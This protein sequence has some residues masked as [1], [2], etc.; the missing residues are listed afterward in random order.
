MVTWV[1]TALLPLCYR[2]VTRVLPDV[3]RM[4][5]RMLPGCSQVLLHR[6]G[7]LFFRL[8]LLICLMKLIL[9]K[10]SLSY[11]R[12]C[13]IIFPKLF[14]GLLWEDARPP[15]PPPESPGHSLYFFNIP[16]NF[17]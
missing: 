8:N 5:T 12:L 2:F 13:N 7:R 1:V 17:L 15:T 3:P 11:S 6:L 10:I 9:E 4:F 16:T 14:G